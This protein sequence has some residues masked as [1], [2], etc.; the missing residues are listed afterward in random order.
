MMAMDVLLVMDDVSERGA[1][2][3]LCS[4]DCM[5]AL[6]FAPILPTYFS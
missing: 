1:S 6:R 2:G 3:R 5:R 4:C